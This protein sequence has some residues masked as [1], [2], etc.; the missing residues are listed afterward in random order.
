MADSFCTQ[1]GARFLEDARFCTGCGH[2]RSGVAPT[3]AAAPTPA[4]APRVAAVA[5]YAPVIVIGGV[6]LMVATAVGVGILFPR[7]PVRIVP[8]QGS[9]AANPNP[10]QPGVPQDHPPLSIPPQV[11]Q[12]I[13][14]LEKKANDNPKDV[15]AWSQ[16]AEVLVRA[17]Q[18]EATYLEGAEKA[19]THLLELDP[20]NLDA[21]RS[22]GNIAFDRDQPQVAIGHYQKYLEIKPDD[23]AVQTDLATMFLAS[24]EAER[25]VRAYDAVLKVDPK[26]FQAHFNLALAYRA[27]G[28]VEA[29]HASLERARDNAPDEKTKQQLTQLLENGLPGPEDVA[30]NAAPQAPAP[31]GEAP[32]F[33][34]AV[35]SI[36]RTHQIIASKVQ[37]IE[38]QSPT[39]AKLTLTGFPMEQ[40]PPEM[41]ALF[42]SR[43]KDRLR[44]AKQAG[45]VTDTVEIAIVDF[46]SGQ[47][48]DTLSE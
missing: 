11:K 31:Q 37:A 46:E 22:L 35:E 40:M 17:G 6:L 9:A 48:M 7:E 3:A 21:R 13:A 8:R 24:G 23:L 19:Y 25:A 30:A 28:Q 5:P 10:A 20:K 18:I 27:A 26:F 41:R 36:F 39:K 44:A 32:S 4:R 47:L 45:G 1:C 12:A 34:T 15:A 42:T 33:Q 29:A 2:P 14:D 38:W 16:L 43:M